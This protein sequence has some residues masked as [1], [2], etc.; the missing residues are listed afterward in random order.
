MY[1]HI[2][3][4]PSQ[5]IATNFGNIATAS[6]FCLQCNLWPKFG[7]ILDTICQ[8]Y[9]SKFP[10][11]PVYMSFHYCTQ[12]ASLLTHKVP[13]TLGLLKLKM[14]P[15]VQ[16]NSHAI[17]TRPS[18]HVSAPD[19]FTAEFW[20]R[21]WKQ[22]CYMQVCYHLQSKENSETVVVHNHPIPSIESSDL[23]IPHQSC[24][25][26]A[27]NNLPHSI[28]CLLALQPSTVYPSCIGAGP[29]SSPGFERGVVRISA[30]SGVAISGTKAACTS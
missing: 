10:Y 30:K 18:E 22:W 12:Y 24:Q 21:N 27:R 20:W 3:S 19:Q 8:H 5:Y 4:Q 11:Q 28:T 1:F 9:F 16:K 6:I 25:W 14:P 23:M 7:K 29:L 13:S 15:F 26:E 2:L 17:V